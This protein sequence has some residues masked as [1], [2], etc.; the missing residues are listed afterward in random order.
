MTSLPSHSLSVSGQS[1]WLDQLSRSMLESDEL[2]I[3][4]V[5]DDVRGVTSNPTIF[6]QSITGST[7]YDEQLAELVDRG[8]SVEEIYTELVATDI[9]QAC[10]KLGDLFK[11]TNGR[12]GLV[13]VEVSPLL[14]HQVAETV[15]DAHAWV[16][17]IDRPNLMVKVPATSAGVKAF[18]QL[19]SEGI[20]VNVTLIFS[21]ERYREIMQAYVEGLSRLIKK[22]GDLTRVNSVASFFVSRIDSWID[23]I[24]EEFDSDE[25]RSSLGSVAISNAIN[26]YREFLSFFLTHPD[27]TNLV[28]HGAAVQ[29]PLWASTS[30]KNPDYSPTMYVD[31]LIAPQTVTTIPP[32]TL[33]IFQIQGAQNQSMIAIETM[34]LAPHGWEMV[35]MLAKEQGKSKLVSS[36]FDDLEAQGVQKFV[37]SYQA[38]L[39]DLENKVDQLKQANT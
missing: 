13:S 26:A 14:A 33:D 37:D 15:A 31:N 2:V 38:L 9:R 29:R 39:K 6:H 36:M 7:D 25:A 5:R 19:T 22:G 27:W 1:I 10:D 8:A 3:R 32:D 11:H 35:K 23:P 30:T 20:S 18:R 24:L 21:V 34:N 12:D 28:A 17:R 16:K 4:V